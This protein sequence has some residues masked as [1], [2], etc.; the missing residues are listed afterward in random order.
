ME[1][2]SYT[3]DNL[4]RLTKTNITNKSTNKKAL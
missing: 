1:S 3:Y 2:Y 4:G